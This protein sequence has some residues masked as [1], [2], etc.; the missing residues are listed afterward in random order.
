MRN[1]ERKRRVVGMRQNGHPELYSPQGES[2]LNFLEKICMKFV[3]RFKIREYETFQAFGHGVLFAHCALKN[4]GLQL[5]GG[6]AHHAQRHKGSPATSVGFQ[7]RQELWGFSVFPPFIRWR[8]IISALPLPEIC[9]QALLKPGHISEVSSYSNQNFHTANSLG[10]PWFM[11][12]DALSSV[13]KK[14]LSLFLCW[15]AGQKGG[16]TKEVM[17]LPA[18]TLLISPSWGWA[19]P[20]EDCWAPALEADTRPFQLTCS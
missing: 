11:P 9:Y 14:L 15:N 8:R 4:Q 6:T 1:R 7:E 19:G 5:F 12:P 18:H 10:H 2:L 20:H 16:W 3:Q 13:L 17:P